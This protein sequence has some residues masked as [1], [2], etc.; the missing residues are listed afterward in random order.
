MIGMKV[1]RRTTLDSKLRESQERT[2]EADKGW[3]QSKS[4]SLK[5]RNKID[6]ANAKE[7]KVLG[8]I[9]FAEQAGRS[10]VGFI[11]LPYWS[12][13]YSLSCFCD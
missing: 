6:V 12:N 7:E 10:S 5:F 1:H 2:P 13:M 3:G 8:F 4:S 11:F 9:L